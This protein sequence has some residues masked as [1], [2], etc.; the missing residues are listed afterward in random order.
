M[1]ADMVHLFEHQCLIEQ[2][3]KLG[4]APRHDW[5]TQLL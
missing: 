4:L 1:H 3:C 5:V 2:F